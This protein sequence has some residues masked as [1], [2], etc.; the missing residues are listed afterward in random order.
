M[1][2]NLSGKTKALLVIL[3]VAF[4]AIIVSGMALNLS[5]ISFPT[6]QYK[7]GMQVVSSI[8]LGVVGIVIILI[9]VDQ[10]GK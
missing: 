10:V 1:L 9:I 5:L 7:L 6:D 2:S 3:I 4:L 8:T